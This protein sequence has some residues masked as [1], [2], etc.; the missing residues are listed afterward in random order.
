MAQ[1]GHLDFHTAPDL[2]LQS[3]SSNVAYVHRNRRL[4]RDGKPRTA[5]STFTA[6]ELCLQSESSQE[7]IL[8]LHVFSMS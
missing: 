1:D 7:F 4:I 5:T 8:E 3:S 6:I 2:C